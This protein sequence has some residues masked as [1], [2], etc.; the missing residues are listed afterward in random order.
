[1]ESLQSGTVVLQNQLHDLQATHETTCKE[2]AD[3]LHYVQEREV[4]VNETTANLHE[5][6]VELQA[7]NEDLAATLKETGEFLCRTKD[8]NDQLEESLNKAERQWESEKKLFLIQ[9]EELVFEK[10]RAESELDDAEIKLKQMEAEMVNQKSQ[11]TDQVGALTNQLDSEKAELMQLQNKLGDLVYEKSQLHTNVGHLEA[12]LKVVKSES[13]DSM[14][15]AN[16]TLGVIPELK[17]RIETLYTEKNVIEKRATEFSKQN[18]TL[19]TTLE[20]FQA[21]FDDYSK[22]VDR[23]KTERLAKILTLTEEIDGL[24]EQKD[25]M[26]QELDDWLTDKSELDIEI[27]KL[28]C[29]IKGIT[30]YDTSFPNNIHMI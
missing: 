12:Q 25:H 15:E 21:D 4:I 5:R 17:H 8:E 10:S 20:F 23:E 9:V 11:S 13:A 30:I 22:T 16:K 24:R 19:Q 26:A 18:D 6:I 2:T 1:M 28:Q 14:M 3:K 29:R 7:Q 27:A